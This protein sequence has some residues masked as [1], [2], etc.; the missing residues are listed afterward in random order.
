MAV[1]KEN[2]VPSPE[3]T[4][5]DDPA[6]FRR[7]IGELRREQDDEQEMITTAEVDTSVT[8]PLVSETVTK[9]NLSDQQIRAMEC[10]ISRE[11]E[12][13][14]AQVA[15]RA[16]VSVRSLY[17]YMKEPGWMAEYRGRIELELGG[18]RGRVASA[19]IRGATTP[20]PGQA[21]MQ[22]IYWQRLG[23]LKDQVE[24]SGPNGGPIQT[25]SDVTYT[26]VDDIYNHITA[27]EWYIYRDIWERAEARLKGADIP[28]F[29]RPIV[30]AILEALDEAM[31]SVPDRF[32]ADKWYPT[33]SGYLALPG[34]RPLGPNMYDALD[35]E[36][37]EAIAAYILQAVAERHDR[38]PGKAPGRQANGSLFELQPAPQPAQLTDG[39]TPAPAAIDGEPAAA[40]P[41]AVVVERTRKRAELEEPEDGSLYL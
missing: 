29:A 7:T 30:D 24:L 12:E 36:H 41:A 32:K 13:T 26:N 14:L 9:A 2:V 34:G 17:R 27:L 40:I 6:D 33:R 25:Q 35:R 18:Q 1:L 28:P 22:K 19:L 8:K 11:P 39:G 37:L 10:L 5:A 15:A 4:Y 20:G 21:A 31:A 16:G 38:D 3:D 23:E